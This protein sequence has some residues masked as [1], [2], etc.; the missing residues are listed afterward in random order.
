MDKIFGMDNNN[1]KPFN[2]VLPRLAER[3]SLKGIMR[4]LMRVDSYDPYF[5]YENH[6][7]EP[8]QANAQYEEELEKR[9][10]E[11]VEFDKRMQAFKD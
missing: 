1:K 4:D 11:K 6:K 9:N 10:G 5:K 7:P 2:E 3:Q 8:E